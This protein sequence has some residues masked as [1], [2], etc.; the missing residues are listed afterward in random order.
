MTVAVEMVAFKSKSWG[1]IPMYDG[2]GEF[3]T[4]WQGQWGYTSPDWEHQKAHG[5]PQVNML[6]GQNA[7]FRQRP[8]QIDTMGRGRSAANFYGKFR[9]SDHGYDLSMD[10]TLDTILAIQDGRMKIVDGYIVGDWTFSKN[11][12]NI[13]LRPYFGDE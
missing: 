4:G 1:V 11:G 13:F 3:F 12:Q 10:G 8:F 7:I 9:D 2:S 5:V 6:I